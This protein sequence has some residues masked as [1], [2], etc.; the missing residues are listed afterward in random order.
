MIAVII[1]YHNQI[2][3]LLHGGNN[4]SILSMSH[5]AFR[6]KIRYV[7]M[8][9]QKW[10]HSFLIQ[11]PLREPPTYVNLRCIHLILKKMVVGAIL[12]QNL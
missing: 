2:S 3:V 11:L 8:Q 4:G 7:T 12:I 1:E 9:V 10:W 6:V 5:T